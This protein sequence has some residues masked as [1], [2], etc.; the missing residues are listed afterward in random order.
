MTKHESV[1]WSLSA[2][3]FYP[4][5]EIVDVEDYSSVQ[6]VGRGS[7]NVEMTQQLNNEDFN[8]S[9]VPSREKPQKRRTKLFVAWHEV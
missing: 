7:N 9:F 6:G 8:G 3:C 5:W 1:E 2:L 4:L